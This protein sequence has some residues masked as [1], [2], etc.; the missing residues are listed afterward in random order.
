[1]AEF[2]VAESGD[3]SRALGVWCLHSDLGNWYQWQD[4]TVTWALKS[5]VAVPDTQVGVQTGSVEITALKVRLEN[6]PG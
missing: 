6:S 2:G 1:M 5:A 3:S 4:L